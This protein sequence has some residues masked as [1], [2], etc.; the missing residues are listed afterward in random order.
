MAWCL[1]FFAAELGA[2]GPRRRPSGSA[3]SA[4]EAACFEASPS[5]PHAL[6]V[7]YRSIYLANDLKP[8]EALARAL[9]QRLRDHERLATSLKDEAA[10]APLRALI[11]R[12]SF[13]V[14][15]NAT[16]FS[17]RLDESEGS[18]LDRSTPPCCRSCSRDADLR[19]GGLPRA[20]SG[21]PT[22]R[23]MSPCRKSTAAS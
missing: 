12:R 7:F 6:V 9:L 4:S 5:A 22:S 15:L 16:A 23:C 13:D 1:D 20:V 14:V 18:V 2:G 17:A 10:I 8:I 11:V 21:R 19:P 3:P